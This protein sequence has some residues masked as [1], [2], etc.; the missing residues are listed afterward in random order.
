MMKNPLINPLQSSVAFH[1]ETSYLFY[2]AKQMTGFYMKCKSG[3]KWVNCNEFSYTISIPAGNFMFKVNNR[4]TR[5]KR[6]ICS[7]STIKTPERHQ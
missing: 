6:E 1:I 4:N 3:L 5:R 7:E 2:S